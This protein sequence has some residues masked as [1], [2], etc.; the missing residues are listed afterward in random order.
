M[1]GLE[2]GKPRIR[3]RGAVDGLKPLLAGALLLYFTPAWWKGQERL[4]RNWHPKEVLC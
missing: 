3:I 4:F 1:T 2:L